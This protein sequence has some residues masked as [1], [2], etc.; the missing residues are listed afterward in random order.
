[1]LTICGCKWCLGICNLINDYVNKNYIPAQHNIVWM[2]V[3]DAEPTEHELEV[4]TQV[5]QVLQYAD[6]TLLNLQQYKGAANEIREVC[7]MLT[8]IIYT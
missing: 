7:I 8:H 5:R 2:S 1:M 4:W 3:S 6:S